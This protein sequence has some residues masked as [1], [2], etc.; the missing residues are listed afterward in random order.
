MEKKPEEYA[1]VEMMGHRKVVAKISESEYGPGSLIK[2]SVL[3]REGGFDRTEHIGVS[4]IYCMTIV[5]KDVAETAAQNMTPEPTFAYSLR[6][7]LLSQGVPQ[8][9]YIDADDDGHDEDF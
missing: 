8:G 2:L 1:V 5:E 4:S 6:N 9:S 3:N 7:K